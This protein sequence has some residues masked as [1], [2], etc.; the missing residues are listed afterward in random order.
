MAS[1]QAQQ[2]LAQA[3]GYQQQLQS[4]MTQ[5]ETFSMQL[6]DIK[7]ALAELEK[8]ESEEVYRIS[9]PL[10]IKSTKAESKQDLKSKEEFIDA[11]IKT[12]ERGEKKIKDRIDELRK[13]LSGS[14]SESEG[15][16]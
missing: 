2:I 13:K 9:G 12:L 11:R 10:L 7:S 5:K 6:E 4:I 8:S 1:E 15:A 16:G 3:Q 14:E